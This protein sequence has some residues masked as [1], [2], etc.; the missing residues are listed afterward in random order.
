MIV[1]YH[2][3]DGSTLDEEVPFAGDLAEVTTAMV[4]TMLTR[5]KDGVMV[6]PLITVN[7]VAQ[8]QGAYAPHNVKRKSLL[9]TDRIVR[10]EFILSDM[11]ERREAGAEGKN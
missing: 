11:E 4:H 1:R 7:A 8:V 3:T 5:T 9:F 6:T 10:M 2:L